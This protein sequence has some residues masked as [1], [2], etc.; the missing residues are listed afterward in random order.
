MKE[1]A[2]RVTMFAMAAVLLAGCG[3]SGKIFGF[4]RSGPDE[5]TVVRNPPLT[6]PPDATL[7]PPQ[8]GSVAYSRERSSNQARNVLATTGSQGTLV[9][10]QGA[11]A[12]GGQ[13]LAG[14]SSPTQYAGTRPASGGEI[15]LV[16]RTTAYY[17]IEPDIRRVVDAESAKLALEQKKFL[18]KVLFWKDP[19]PPGTVLDANAEQRRLRENEALGKPMNAGEAPLIARKK[20]GITSLF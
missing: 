9:T 10:E 8:P 14:A 11:Q 18:H 3:E 2:K 7:R 20:S 4:D 6:L 16:Q 15:A 13:P 17:G 12:Y 1:T 5:F 19:E